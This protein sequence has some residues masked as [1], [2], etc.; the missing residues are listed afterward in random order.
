[1]N[2]IDQLM[3][4]EAIRSLKARYFRCMD[5]KDWLAFEALFTP[6]AIF[7]MRQARGADI[8]PAGFVQGASCITA[9]VRKAVDRLVT[10]HHGH[11]PE[12]H[13]ETESFARGVWAMEDVLLVPE[14]VD[15]P[16]EQLRGYGHYHE[17]YERIA[18]EWKIKTCRLTRL[19]VAAS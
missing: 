13:I 16:F 9:Y 17:S 2:A 1:M 12:I 18:G 8:D 6:A 3:A 4:I 14:G 19:H 7:D 11:M 15:M 5:T 10:V